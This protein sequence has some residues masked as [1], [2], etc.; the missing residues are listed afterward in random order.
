MNFIETIAIVIAGVFARTM[1]H[2]LVFIA[3]LPQGIVDGI[4]VVVVNQTAISKWLP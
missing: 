4:F 1:T 3:P 2:C